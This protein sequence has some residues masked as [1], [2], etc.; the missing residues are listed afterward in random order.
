M[1][2]EFKCRECNSLLRLKE[3]K[4]DEEVLKNKISEIEGQLEELR[5]SVI[6][7]IVPKEKREVKKKSVKKPVKKKK[8]ANASDTR[9]ESKS[10]IRGQKRNMTTLRIVSAMASSHVSPIPNSIGNERFYSES[11]LQSDF[12]MTPNRS[13]GTSFDS[14]S[15]GYFD[16]ALMSE[17]SDG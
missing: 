12:P 8:V 16:S 14:V 9:K 2:I 11:S 4:Y 7:E 13:T 3:V 1:E 15:P 17:A 5:K 10:P 6:V